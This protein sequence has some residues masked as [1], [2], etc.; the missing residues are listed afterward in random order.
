[1]KK[2]IILLL[3]ILAA[4][5]A[6]F[7]PLRI[8]AFDTLLSYAPC[9]QPIPYR[10]GTIDNRFGLTEEE[11][12]ADVE[13]A[14]Q[15]WSSTI[16]RTLFVYD[17]EAELSINLVYDRRQDLSNQI[18]NLKGEIENEK[19]EM[20]PEIAEYER[21]S[22]DFRQRMDALNSEI[23]HWNSQGGA[24]EDVYSRLKSEQEALQAE[25]ES[26]NAMARRLNQTSDEFSTKV[27]ELNQTVRQFNSALN[28]RPE[29]G[30]Y[31]PNTNTITI[32]FHTDKTEFIHTL[33][34]ELGHALGLG[35]VE[36]PESIMYEQTNLRTTPTAEDTAALMEVCRRK[37]Y[38]ELAQDRF[39]VLYNFYFNRD[40]TIATH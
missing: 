1:M 2:A 8:Q 29:E 5:F 23:Q 39:E 34:H 15:A 31:D 18:N 17:P 14:S 36:N 35:H 33:A 16:G 26:L 3:I 4:G 21:R 9:E 25:A 10:I 13:T 7:N 32:Y 40:A 12:R 28:V 37:S 30:L 20:E 27:G 38:A 19:S 24:P 6:F 22:A 11:L